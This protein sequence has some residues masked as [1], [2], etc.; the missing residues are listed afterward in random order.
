MTE[1]YLFSFGGNNLYQAA[2]RKKLLYYMACFDGEEFGKNLNIADVLDL[3]L[4]HHI[5][6]SSAV[7]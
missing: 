5:K 3:K 7:N 1:I 6:P 4:E 2:N